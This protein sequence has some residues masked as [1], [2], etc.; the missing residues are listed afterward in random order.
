MN[1]TTTITSFQFKNR[2]FIITLDS[3]LDENDES[4]EL[5]EKVTVKGKPLK[6][7]LVS[8][9]IQN[10][11]VPIAFASRNGKTGQVEI[12]MH[13]EGLPLEP[14]LRFVASIQNQWK[15]G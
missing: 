15:K 14:L 4:M 5:C 2:R 11:T 6:H 8:D 1:K 12:S 7:L 13:H 9:G 10:K 3:S